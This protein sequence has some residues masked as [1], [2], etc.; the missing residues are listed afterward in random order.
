MKMCEG[1]G[2]HRIHP[3][4]PPDLLEQGFCLNCIIISD[5]ERDY[6]AKHKPKTMMQ[7]VGSLIPIMAMSNWAKFHDIGV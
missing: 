5:V 4:T 3:K 7:L 2:V 6:W 1:C